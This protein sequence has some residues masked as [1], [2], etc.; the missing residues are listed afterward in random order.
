MSGIHFF[1]RGKGYPLVLIHGFCETGNMWADFAEA[2]SNEF[3]VICPDLP[4]IANSPISEDQITLEE[5]AVSL[6]DWMK[7]NQIENPIVIGHSLGGY[8]SLALLELMGNRIKA[9][10][11]FH[12]TAFADD[13][14]KKEMRNRTI[15]F[16]RKYG[17]EK[18]VT[19]FVPPLFSEN[20]RAEL[21]KEIELAIEDG[22]RSTLNGLIA[23]AGAMRDRKERL[24]ILKLYSGPKLLIAGTEDAAVKIESSR[25]QKD[26]FSHYYELQGVGHM[27]MVESKEETLELIRAF[28]LES[29]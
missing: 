15:T 19:S 14:E 13:G 27:G 1:E 17:V 8:V 7:V 4:G 28:A 29:L 9:I 24:D 5:V 6:E 10:G 21:S 11:L 20:R 23:Y 18:F 26:V 12:S 3:R 25:A 22:K 2:L 16:L